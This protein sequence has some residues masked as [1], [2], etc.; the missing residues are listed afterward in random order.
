MATVAAVVLAGG[1]TSPELRAQTG[2]EDRARLPF[3]GKEMV[4]WVIEALQASACVGPM[5]VVGAVAPSERY[6]VAEAGE[7]FLESVRNGVAALDPAEGYLLVTG[8]IPFLTADAITDFTRKATASGGDF[9]YAIVRKADCL[10]EFPT[11]KR[12]CLKLKEGEF[13]GGNIVYVTQGF[14][15]DNWSRLEEAHRL[16]KNKFRLAATIGFGTLL[17]AVLAQA[18]PAALSIFA[19]EKAA[20]RLVGGKVKAIISPYAGVGTDIDSLE[21]WKALNA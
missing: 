12:T 16:R 2:V 1:K 7:T 18:L 10:R 15:R 20:S 13:T 14:L 4:R 5:A 3:R 19:A 11:M 17:R 6:S 21:H 9:C 8:D